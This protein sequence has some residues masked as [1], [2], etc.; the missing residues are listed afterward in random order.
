MT[1]WA[2]VVGNIAVEITSISPEGRFT[3]NIEAEFQEVP[4]NTQPGATWNGDDWVNPQAVSPPSPSPAVRIYPTVTIPAFMLLFTSA[5]R[6]SIRAKVA[7][8]GSPD[9]TLNDWWAILQDSRTLTVDLNSNGSLLAL[10]YLASQ[11][12]IESNR[13]DLIRSGVPL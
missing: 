4:D 5:E 1:T 11:R 12:Y 6:V 9:A 13:V 8:T 7:N 10:Q 3:P 2:R